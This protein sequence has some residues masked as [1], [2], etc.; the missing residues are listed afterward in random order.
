MSA[1]FVSVQLTTL[2]TEGTIIIINM[3]DTSFTV[4]LTSKKTVKQAGSDGLF[5]REI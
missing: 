3:V 4:H 2:P 5:S 1:D